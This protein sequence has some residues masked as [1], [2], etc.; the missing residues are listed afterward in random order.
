MIP[1]E[2]AN[3]EKA[4]IAQNST[5]NHGPT[6]ACSARPSLEQEGDAV[7][8]VGPAVE[9]RVRQH[10]GQAI[11]A[12]VTSTKVSA[13]STLAK[14]HQRSQRDMLAALVSKMKVC[15][16]GAASSTPVTGL[17]SRGT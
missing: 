6:M 12:N 1:I 11:V 4:P 14:R 9:R 5:P 8:Q 10:R 15:A 17:T 13:C 2:V 16:V 7:R 3:S